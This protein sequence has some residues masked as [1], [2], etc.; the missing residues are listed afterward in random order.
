M[1]LYA[2]QYLE[3]LPEGLTPQQARDGLRRAFDRL[4]LSMILLGWNVPPEI[5]AACAAETARQGAKLYQWH[6]LLTGDATTPAEWQTQNRHGAAIPGYRGLPEFTFLC[7]SRPGV[8]DFASERLEQVFQRGVYQGVFLDRI[9]FPSPFADPLNQLGCF[10]P[11]CQS[12]ARNFDFNVLR[13]ELDTLEASAAGR[14]QLVQRLFTDEGTSISIIGAFLAFRKQ[15]ILNV[16]K[17]A[18]GLIRAQG[19]EVGLDC[20]SPTLTHAVGQDLFALDVLCDWIKP[21]IYAHTHG[22]AGLPFEILE[23]L[24]WLVKNGLTEAE[25]LKLITEVSG[26]PLPATTAQLQS[27]GLSPYAIQLETQRAKQAEVRKVLAG[28]ALVTLPGVNDVQAAQLDLEL[29]AYR[30]GGADGL[31]LSWDLWHIPSERLEQVAKFQ[32]A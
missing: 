14:K 28:V 18:A 3:Y 31:T 5:E 11:V 29:A 19:L 15:S 25:A 7:P 12:K 10:C 1:T 16:V 21:M 8:R 30:T 6:P 26:L 2:A 22:P 13:A 9:R 23:L 17:M 32:A 27:E 4:P 24:G 20:F